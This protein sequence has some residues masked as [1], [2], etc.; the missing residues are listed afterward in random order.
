M[1]IIIQLVAASL[2]SMG[3]ASGPLF[4]QAQDKSSEPV[5]DEAKMDP[6]GVPGSPSTQGGAAPAAASGSSS[7]TSS[8]TSSGASGPGKDRA[9]TSEE[10]VTM[11]RDASKADAKGIPGSP[12]T[13]SGENSKSD[14]KP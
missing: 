8:D 6:K 12:T 3:A 7:G 11:S 13:Q 4:A 1:K 5:K 14:Q 9:A 10:E 2:L